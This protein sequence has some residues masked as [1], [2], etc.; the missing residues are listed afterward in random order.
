LIST[1][2]RKKSPGIVPSLPSIRFG[3]PTPAAILAALD[4]EG[5][6]WAQEQQLIVEQ[7]HP[8]SARLGEGMQ[9][10][11]EQASSRQIAD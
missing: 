5:T 3:Q 7:R 9:F 4:A 11:S 1:T 2:L 8:H 6:G 10:R